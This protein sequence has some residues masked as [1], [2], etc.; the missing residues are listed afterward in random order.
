MRT[1][2]VCASKKYKDEVASFCEE[3]RGR[4]VVVFEPNIQQP[5]AEDSFIHSEH[6]TKTIF[7]GLTLEH[8]DLIRKAD[9]CFVYNPGG[10]VGVSVTLEMGYANALGKPIY[11]LADKTGDPCRD[12]LIDLVAP[13]A[14]ELIAQL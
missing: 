13:T 6:V 11:A 1:V 5:I 12:A 3:L 4:G 7:K 14:A 9:V 8:F 2:C 10:Y